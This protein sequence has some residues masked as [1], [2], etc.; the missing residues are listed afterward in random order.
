MGVEGE[1]RAG[2]V[3][4]PRDNV[5]A[6]RLILLQRDF[7]AFGR[8]QPAQELGGGG[9]VAG[10]VLRIDRDQIRQFALHAGDVG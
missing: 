7:E 3:L 4:E 10:R 6:R 9:L 8:Q 5:D 2:A 1:H